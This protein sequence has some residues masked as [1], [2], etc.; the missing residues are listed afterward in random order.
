MKNNY[1]IRYAIYGML[2]GLLFPIFS[3]I[4][5]LS[6]QELKFSLENIIA[7]QKNSPLLTV[8]DS[9][10]LFLGIFAGLTGRQHDRLADV[11]IE[12]EKLIV[13]R[14]EAIEEL[15]SLQINLENIISERT[16]SLERRTLD[17]QA[18]A[19]I[20]LATVTI[21]NLS[22]LLN[23]VADLIH[24]RFGV[25]HVGIFL[26]D[27]NKENAVLRVANSAGGKMMLKRQHQLKIGEEGIVGYVAFNKEPRLW[28][29]HWL[30]A[31]SYW[32][33]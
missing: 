8:I 24:Q 9:A 28:L 20:G 30:L 22:D 32:V 6:F 26:L 19:D 14:N 17:L 2:F 4:G 18:A 33:F 3:T 12:L 7:V 16:R 29:Y 23:Q 5:E 1:T 31:I 10:P 27:D 13:N 21:H 25:Y 11:N 15:N